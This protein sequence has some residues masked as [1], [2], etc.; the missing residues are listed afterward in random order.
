MSP[1]LETVGYG[2]TARHAEAWGD[3]PGADPIAAPCS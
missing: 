1:L 3:Q 2:K